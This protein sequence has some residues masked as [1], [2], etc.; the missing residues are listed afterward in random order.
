MGMAIFLQPVCLWK[1]VRC[2]CEKVTGGP[3]AVTRKAAERSMCQLLSIL[4]RGDFIQRHL[5]PLLCGQD[6]IQEKFDEA[7]SL[8]GNEW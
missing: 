3:F 5:N 2:F 6:L 1:K 8:P 7:A 4:R